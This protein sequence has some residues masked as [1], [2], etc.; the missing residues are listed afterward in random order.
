MAFPIEALAEDTR[1]VRTTFRL[2][3]RAA[4][5]PG[6]LVYLVSFA[7]LSALI[8]SVQGFVGTDDYYHARMA[9]LILQQGR[10]R[11]D[12][13]WLPQTI[14]SNERFVDHHL[15]FHLFVAPWA[16]WGGMTGA[17]L[18]TSGIAAGVFAA[19]WALLRAIGVRRAGLWTLGLFAMSSPFLYRLLMVRTQGAA[20][21][22]IVIALYLLVTRRER[23]L[24]PLAFAFAWLYN[25]FALILGVVAL[26]SVSILIVEHR[27]A[28]RAPVYTALGLLLG[29]VINPYFPNNIAFMVDHLGAKLD[30]ESGVRVGS[31]WYP[32]STSA[33]LINAG[34]ALA[35]LA[36][37]TLRGS[38]GARKRDTAETAL[39]LVALLTLF[40]LLRSRRFVEYF[41]AFALLF[42]AA[43]W[44]RA[45][46]RWSDWLSRRWMRRMALGMG[47]IVLVGVTA[48]TLR[49]A[50][51]DIRTSASGDDLSGAAGWLAAN[52]APGTPVFQT[53]WDDFTRLFYANTSNTYLVGLDPTYLQ[54]ADPA[55]WDTWVAITQG[56]VAQPSRLIRAQFGAAY[57][58]SDTRH[59]AFAAQTHDDPGLELV[60]RD[61]DALVWRVTDAGPDS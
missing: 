2:N 35:A 22:L 28:W 37:G 36:F 58:I 51:D 54:L 61:A 32:Y 12:F 11:I 27:L 13:P 23:W 53:D 44:G 59:D 29:L 10:L 6:L 26:Y 42:C 47:A 57:V 7:V 5:L 33:L 60:Y 55:L 39:L 9:D 50:L 46:V 31:E 3:V 38:F 34:G 16:H 49:G 21:L 8:F 14:L 15:L 41:P 48:L 1:F 56:R 20:L 30:F 40:M 52:S 25:G 43:A 17:K 45:G 18:A 19:A 4:W 24:L